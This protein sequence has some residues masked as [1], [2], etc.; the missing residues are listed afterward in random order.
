VELDDIQV[1]GLHA[2][3]AL[4]HGV[5]DALLAVV[6]QA[7]QWDSEPCALV[8]GKPGHIQ[9]APALGGQEE[10]LTAAGDAPADVLFSLAVVHGNINRHY[11]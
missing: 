3:Q 8:R 1:A 4:V 6:M 10:L 11:P 5:H 9:R 2:P 7:G